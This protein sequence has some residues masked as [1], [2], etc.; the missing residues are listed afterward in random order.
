[1]GLQSR[2]TRLFTEA[3]SAWTSQAGP[4]STAFLSG[5]PSQPIC[6]SSIH[7]APCPQLLPTFCSLQAHLF[8][9]CLTT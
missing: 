8:L 3:G 7:L 1:M 6:L 5:P 4:G 2:Y 9:T